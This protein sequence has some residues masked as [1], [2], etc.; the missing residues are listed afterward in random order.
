MGVFERFHDAIVV[1]GRQIN[2]FFLHDVVVHFSDG[3]WSSEFDLIDEF[4]G[5]NGKIRPFCITF[6]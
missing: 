6:I 4:G 2:S 5:F 1:N 3:E